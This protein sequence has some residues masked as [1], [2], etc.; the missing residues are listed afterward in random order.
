MTLWVKAVP[1]GSAISIILTL[2]FVT[3]A[4][5]QET[6]QRLLEHF[7]DPYEALECGEFPLFERLKFERC[8]FGYLRDLRTYA[9][10]RDALR[11]ERFEIEKSRAWLWFSA[12]P[13]VGNCNTLPDLE[14]AKFDYQCAPR[15]S[16]DGAVG[17]FEVKLS[18]LQS[19]RDALAARMAIVRSDFERLSAKASRQLAVT[20][21]E[22][23]ALGEVLAK[24]DQAERRSALLRRFSI[25]AQ[26]LQGIDL[27]AMERISIVTAP[28]ALA[29][30]R[31]PDTEAPLVG[32]TRGGGDVVVVVGEA[33]DDAA[34]LIL[35]H[36]DFG[37]VY[38]SKSEFYAR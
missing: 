14:K 36:P 35:V 34:S 37:V 13:A 21:P 10:D 17:L 25:E 38:A 27:A 18:Q 1:S 12:P 19:Q 7:S 3:G 22:V 32:Q 6:G 9:D 15:A 5:A 23:Q 33:Q 4:A 31:G 30:R 2:L 20:P 28:A 24:L 8:R 16:S 26:R 29:L 11:R